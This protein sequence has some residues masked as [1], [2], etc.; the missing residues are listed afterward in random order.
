MGGRVSSPARA[1]HSGGKLA[2]NM[3][4]HSFNW[5]SLQQQGV[6]VH[7]R[8][9]MITEHSHKNH[10]H[11]KSHAYMFFKTWTHPFKYT[12]YVIMDDIL[13]LL[14]SSVRLILNSPLAHVRMIADS[15]EDS[16]GMRRDFAVDSTT[17]RKCWHFF[18]CGSK[19]LIC[20][21]VSMECVWMDVCVCVWERERERERGREKGQVPT[22]KTHPNR[23]CVIRCKISFNCPNH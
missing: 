7:R 16:C 18:S 11:D 9:V 6:W 2:L 20:G 23:L 1:S 5:S 17:N 22:E 15:L 21:Q 8:L 4:R 14:Y 10:S 3:V 19:K 13:H 12:Q